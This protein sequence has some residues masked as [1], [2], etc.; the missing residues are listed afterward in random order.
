M[1][2]ILEIAQDMAPHCGIAAVT[3]LVSSQDE[4]ER[5]ILRCLNEAGAEMQSRFDWPQLRKTVTLAGAGNIEYSLPT[6]F[7]RLVKGFSIKTETGT[8]VRGSLS[9]DEFNRLTSVAG[10]PRY[11]RQTDV[12]IEFWPYVNAPATVTVQYISKD[13]LSGDS[14]KIVADGSTPLFDDEAL[15]KGA[16]WRWRRMNGHEYKD[17]LDEY[18]ADLARYSSFARTERR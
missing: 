8:P 4:T 13:W 14:D 9:D 12:S 7:S 10:V 6:D 1:K 11:F 15:R 16:L 17:W 18:E 5:S 3:A 2:S